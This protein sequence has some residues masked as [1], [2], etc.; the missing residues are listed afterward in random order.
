MDKLLAGAKANAANENTLDY[1]AGYAL[2]PEDAEK[3]LAKVKEL[4][5]GPRLLTRVARMKPVGDEPMFD[6]GGNAA[7]WCVDENGKPVA[8]GGCAI[9]PRDDRSKPM[10][11]P[12][13]YIGFRVVK[14]KTPE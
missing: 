4:G 10:K 7:E 9:M 5:D 1:W 11:P 8:K 14:L 6:L 13:E 3:L 2:N 12:A